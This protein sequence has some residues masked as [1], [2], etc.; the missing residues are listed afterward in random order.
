MSWSINLSGPPQVVAREL[1]DAILLLDK[2]TDW[3]EKSISDV[4]SVNLAG[5]VSW[6]GTGDITASSVSFS[7]GES[8]NPS[9][10]TKSES[11]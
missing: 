9:E 4:L 5:Y 8:N 11:S 6:T 10:D 2:A 3:V 1:A 7:V